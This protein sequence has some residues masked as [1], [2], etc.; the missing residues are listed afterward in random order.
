M[1]NK[2]IRDLKKIKSAKPDE[3][4]LKSDDE[5]SDDPLDLEDFVPGSKDQSK[6]KGIFRDNYGVEMQ[7]PGFYILDAKVYPKDLNYLVRVVRFVA[8]NKDK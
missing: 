4:D 3:K 8:P 7:Y 1:Q 6:N 2:M 5:E